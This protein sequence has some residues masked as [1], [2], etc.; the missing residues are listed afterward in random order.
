MFYLDGSTYKVRVWGTN[1]KVVGA[2]KI[3]TFK[4]NGKTYRVKTNKYGYAILK[5]TQLPKRYVVTASY[6]SAKV[7]NV[8]VVKRILVSKNVIVKKSAK[9][10]ILT[11]SLKKV[12]GKYLSGKVIKFR[13]YGKT[14]SAKKNKK[15]IAKVIIKKNVINKLKAGKKYAFKV[16]YV[17]D[18]ISKIAVVRR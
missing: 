15:G 2:G 10:V 1:G 8:I 17:K 13:F 9:R 16:T 5:I 6:G 7:S 12:K 4:F 18:S 3:V 11:A 14:Y